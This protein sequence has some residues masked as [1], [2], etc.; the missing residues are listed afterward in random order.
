M[1]VTKNAVRPEGSVYLHIL[2]KEGVGR[3]QEQIVEVISS[4]TVEEIS[5]Y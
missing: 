4:G 2:V 1:S 3:S 5:G